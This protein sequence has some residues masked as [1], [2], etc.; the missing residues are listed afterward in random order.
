MIM[1]SEDVA[2]YLKDHPEFFEEYADLLG[3]IYIPHPHGGRAIPLSERQMLTL[4]E[5]S[6]VLEGKLR[7]L[8]QFGEE[9]DSISDRLHRVM[10]ALLK[11]RDLPTLLDALYENVQRDFAV[12]A[13]IVRMWPNTL[14]L[15]RG[16]FAEVS[17]EARVFAES[18]SEAYFS[19][20]PMYESASWLPPEHTI[21]SLVY[22]PL[23]AEQTF[24]LLVLGS[25]DAERF[26][27]DKGT[28][29]LTRLSEAVSMALRRYCEV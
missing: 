15:E 3:S 17:A 28:L 8:V 11:A 10:L 16:E 25:E 9:N 14:A 24:G 20:Q 27:S 26:A 19:A 22:L 5:K 12:P 6:K 4:R 23:R 21:A 2:R 29:Y 1:N 18:L 7:E 13:V